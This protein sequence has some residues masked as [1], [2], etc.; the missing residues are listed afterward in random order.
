MLNYAELCNFMQV[1]LKS[2]AKVGFGPCCPPA[3]REEPAAVPVLAEPAPS[4]V[5]QAAG[6]GGKRPKG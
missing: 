4:Q 2:Y 3:S 1:M 6:R 5:V